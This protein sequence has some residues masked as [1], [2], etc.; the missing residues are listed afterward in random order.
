MMFQPWHFWLLS[1][2]L[3]L[4]I[5]LLTTSMVALTFAV[6]AFLTLLA[7][8]ADIPLWIQP[9][10]FATSAAIS[11]PFLKKRFSERL[12]SPRESSLA[13][14]SFPAKGHLVIDANGQLKVNI[15]NDLYFIRS[16]H[17]QKLQQG[18]VVTVIEINGLTA[19]VE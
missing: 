4:I 11:A 5:E 9:I 15:D 1:V 8:F 7:S 12:I 10:V 14:E 3:L 2:I 18:D 16:D 19:L 6:A 17:L 13:G